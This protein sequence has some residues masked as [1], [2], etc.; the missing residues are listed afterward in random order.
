MKKPLA[1]LAVAA[2]ATFASFADTTATYTTGDTSLADGAKVKV[3]GTLDAATLS[4]IRLNG[5]R[6]AQNGDGYLGIPGF[7]LIIL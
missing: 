2:S 6:V 1:L 7:M 4:R 3:N 5:R